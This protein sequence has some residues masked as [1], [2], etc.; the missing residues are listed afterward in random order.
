MEITQV[1][2]HKVF[3]LGNYSNEKIGID[4][5]LQPGENPL[6]AFAEAKRIVEKSH[7]FFTDLPKYEQ[8][9][10]VNNN[11]DDFTGREVKAA[12][13]IIAAF[14]ANYPDYIEKFIP[15]SRQLNEGVGSDYDASNDEPW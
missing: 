1:S 13:E 11:P 2:Y 8:A 12:H 14:K 3:N 15:A 10:R 4:I 9:Q 7:S 5:K 6:D